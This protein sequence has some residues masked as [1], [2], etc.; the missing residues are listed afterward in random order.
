[1]IQ[2]MLDSIRSKVHLDGIL[3][4]RAK[5]RANQTT[6]DSSTEETPII[7]S[8][9]GDFSQKDMGSSSSYSILLFLPMLKVTR[10]I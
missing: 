7:K 5:H 6:I 9:K 8:Q 3:L 10:M 1:M 2:N 4:E